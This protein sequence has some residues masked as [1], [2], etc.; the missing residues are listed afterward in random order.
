MKI[1]WILDLQGGEGGTESVT[2]RLDAAVTSR[3]NQFVTVLTGASWK[4]RNWE[5]KLSKVYI[6]SALVPM[7]IYTL[8]KVL[9]PFVRYIKDIIRWE[10]PDIIVAN[11]APMVLVLRRILRWTGYHGNSNIIVYEH[12]A[13]ARL[14]SGSI[15][16][17]WIYRQG[18]KE[19]DHVICGGDDYAI[20]IE[21]IGSNVM[22]SAIGLPITVRKNLI[23]RSNNVFYIVFVGRLENKQKRVDRLLKACSLLPSGI[24]W[25]LQ[26]I[27]DGPDRVALENMAYVL[28]VEK[29]VI[30]SGWQS[31]PWSLIDSASILAFPSDFEGFS[32]VMIEAMAHGLPVLSTDCDFG[33]R[34]IIAEGVNGWLVDRNDQAFAQKLQQLA[35]G[36]VSLPNQ[37]SI[38]R[39]VDRFNIDQVA[40]RFLGVCEK[41]R[42]SQQ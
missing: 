18:V 4:N 25:L 42:Q 22:V 19:S 40:E 38:A 1:L 11:W 15:L 7:R 41:V 39:T 34:S 16:Y 28:N 9:V 31:D 32:A 37:E 35:I 24:D 13:F 36:E 12:G 3:G 21:K 6:G 2:L 5:S 29:H 27:G 30:W 8:P 23:P 14:S 17:R 33:P 10:K 20:E 26:I